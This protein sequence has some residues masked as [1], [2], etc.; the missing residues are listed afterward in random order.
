MRRIAVAKKDRI[1]VDTETRRKKQQALMIRAIERKV[2]SR[3]QELYESRGQE[4][5]QDLQDWFQAESEIFEN[6]A[7]ASLYRRLKASSSQESEQAMPEAM[8]EQP[9]CES[10]A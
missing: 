6:N 5:G 9:A 8:N 1:T 4:Q 2:R 3:A 10:N 7:V